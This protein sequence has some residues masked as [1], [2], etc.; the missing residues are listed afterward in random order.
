MATFKSLVEAKSKT[1]EDRAAALAELARVSDRVQATTAA[2][3]DQRKRIGKALERAP[4]NS[5]GPFTRPDGSLYT[6]EKDGSGGYTEAPLF[7]PD[8]EVEDEGPA[9]TEDDGT[10]EAGNAPGDEPVPTE[11]AVT[12]DENRIA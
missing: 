10:D 12:E 8:F 1:S 2:D 4:G 3:D 11:E 5:V 6:I 9:P 7:P